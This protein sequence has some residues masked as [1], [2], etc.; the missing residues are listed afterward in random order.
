[1]FCSPIFF[2]FWT[3]TPPGPRFGGCALSACPPCV[4]GHRA[5]MWS[6]AVSGK[7]VLCVFFFSSSLLL[8][9]GAAFRAIALCGADPAAERSSAGAGGA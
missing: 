7:M 5:H 9:L 3:S 8:V 2:F 6:A 1:M 4:C